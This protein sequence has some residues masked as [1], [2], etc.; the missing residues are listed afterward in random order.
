M[1]NQNTKLVTEQKEWDVVLKE[2]DA[3]NLKPAF[4]DHT[5][6][7]ELGDVTDKKVLD[8]GAG[9][10][11]FAFALKKLGA[12]VKVW[13]IGME[14][15]EKSTQKIGV[16]NVY[17]TLEEVP[18]NYFDFVICNLVVCIVPEDEVRAIVRNI[19]EELNEDGLAYIGFC[20]PKIFDVKESQLDLRFQTGDPYEA[21][22]NYKKVKKEGSYEIIETHRPIE[23]YDQVFTEAGM[24]VVDKLFTPE[25]ELNGIKIKDFIIF[26]LSK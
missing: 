12:D 18:K 19:K 2:L 13:D 1:D 23:W 10:G 7:A 11:V 6:I 14:M 22:H 17:N 26:K 15:R 24:K 8:Y 16:D 9:P 20:N 21:N 4:Y 5:V 3:E 25:Y